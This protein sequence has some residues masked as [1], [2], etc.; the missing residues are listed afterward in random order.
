LRP[1][2]STR[3]ARSENGQQRP[4]E[5][6]EQLTVSAK[7]KQQLT[8]EDSVYFQ[9]IYYDFESGDVSQYYDPAKAHRRLRVDE[10][11]EPILL[12]GYH[13]EWNPGNHTLLLVGRMQDTFTVTDPDAMRTVPAG[14]AP[15]P[16]AAPCMPGPAQGRGR[17]F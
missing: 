10:M 5:D 2:S 4:N 14:P 15:W 13:R 11:Q 12:A 3:A 1:P 16:P 7:F 8:P 6:I 9:A 17:A